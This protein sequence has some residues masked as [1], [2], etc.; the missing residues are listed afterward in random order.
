[1][2]AGRQ[3]QSTGH[4]QGKRWGGRARTLVSHFMKRGYKEALGKQH[5]ESGLVGK[6]DGPGPQELMLRRLAKS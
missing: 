3:V 2:E 5:S 6:T 1:M 4:L